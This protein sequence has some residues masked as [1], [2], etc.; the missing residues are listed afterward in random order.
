MKATNPRLYN[1]ENGGNHFQKSFFIGK[2]ELWEIFFQ[3]Y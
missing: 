1:I 2:I 3:Y